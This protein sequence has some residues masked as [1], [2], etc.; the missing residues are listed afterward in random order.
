MKD[1]VF[2]IAEAGVNHNGDMGL[3]RELVHAA[4]DAGADAVKFQ[5]FTAERLASS[6]A[7][8]ADYQLKTTDSKESQFAMLKKLELPYD[9]HAGLMEL[10]NK[11]GIEFMSTPF[12]IVAA[13]FLKTLGV[14]RFKI[15]S[16]EIT[17]FPYLKHVAKLGL[18]TIFS[19]GMASLEDID[20]CLSVLRR[21]GLSR[22]QITVLHCNT[23]YPTPIEDVNL[24]AM[25]EIKER[26]GVK[27]GYSDHTSGIE[28]SLAAAALGASLIE[29]HFTISRSL[30]GPDQKASLEPDELKKLVHG[31]RIVST[32]LG[33]AIKAPSRSEKKNI[34]I[35]RKS[36]V[37]S[38][39]IALGEVFTE[40]NLTTKRPGSGVSPMQWE[41][42]LGRKS[43]RAYQA[44]EALDPFTGDV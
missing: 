16:G 40:K 17:N 10:A 39:E 26:F 34:V 37:A 35:A 27:V 4:A 2:F 36:I 25:Q 32:S 44:D 13:D 1:H 11:L 24:R 6:H 29:K 20:A 33:M 7:P 12:D 9:Q 43:T 3:A 30:A 22:E 5:T 21:F 38:S 19:T 28:V 8:K 41:N 18:P 42:Y 23:E 15:P 31:V 14:R